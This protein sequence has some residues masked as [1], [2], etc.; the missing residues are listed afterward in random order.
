MYMCNKFL[1]G[2]IKKKA[3]IL[4]IYEEQKWMTEEKVL[5]KYLAF[6]LLFEV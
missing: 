2:Y 1:K 3:V 6:H 4:A 5:K